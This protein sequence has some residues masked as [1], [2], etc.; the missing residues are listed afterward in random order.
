M[1]RFSFYISETKD[2]DL[3]GFLNDVGT[4]R[5][6][7]VAKLCLKGLFDNESAQKALNLAKNKPSKIKEPDFKDG[8]SRVRIVFSDKK[9][10]EVIN[11]LQSVKNNSRSM[12]AKIAIRQILG[13]QILLKYFLR[14][15]AE[16]FF[17]ENVYVPVRTV[18]ITQN[19]DISSYKARE[20]YINTK[21]NPDYSN[22]NETK[23]LEQ[24]TAS[25]LTVSNQNHNI[26]EKQV[27]V[28][29]PISI[30]TPSSYIVEDDSSDTDDF[31]M[32]SMLEDML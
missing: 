11:I 9:D 10:L 21:E 4:N 6:R 13:P 19:I 31:D 18:N 24:K 12:F 1:I 29:K 5:F 28:L 2:P 17:A 15:S 26:E 16:S 14:D 27:D 32:L 20:E 8:Y 7:E 30:P 22:Y 25:S 3:C 23:G